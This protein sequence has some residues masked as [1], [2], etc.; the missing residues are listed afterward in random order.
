MVREGLHSGDAPDVEMSEV[1]ADSGSGRTMGGGGASTSGGEEGAGHTQKFFFVADA[2]HEEE[3]VAL[4]RE[5][6]REGGVKHKKK[7]RD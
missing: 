6:G 5:R 2:P 7:G 3:G 1:A 4:R